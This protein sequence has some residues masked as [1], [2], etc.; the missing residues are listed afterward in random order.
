MKFVMVFC[1]NPE[2]SFHLKF[3]KLNGTYFMTRKR[4]D[5]WNEDYTMCFEWKHTYQIETSP[6]KYPILYFGYM[7][8][9][10]FCCSFPWCLNVWFSPAPIFFPLNFILSKKLCFLPS[11]CLLSV[12]F[13]L[14]N[15]QVKYSV[16]NRMDL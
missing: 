6:V 12:T 1:R 16:L 15:R 7:N 13:I 14:N 5:S 9:L 3:S 2:F 11:F 8:D 4:K 10:F